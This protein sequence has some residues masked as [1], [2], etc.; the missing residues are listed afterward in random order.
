MISG[1]SYF[2]DIPIFRRFQFLAGDSLLNI[3]LPK[4]L[5]YKLFT[6]WKLRFLL[7]GKEMIKIAIIECR[8]L[9]LLLVKAAR[10]ILRYQ[11]MIFK[12]IL[13]VCGDSILLRNLIDGKVQT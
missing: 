9:N 3:S 10:I 5:P 2:S 11:I 12:S 13:D 8:K 4:S 6:D 1:S 7:W